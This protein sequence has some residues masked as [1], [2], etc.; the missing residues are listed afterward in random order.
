MALPAALAIG[1]GASL[2]GSL[3]DN[4]QQPD[5]QT[6]S[7]L[8][9]EQQQLARELASII[10]GGLRRG[11][12]RYTGQLSAGVPSIMGRAQATVADLMGSTLV[13]T[14]AMPT[15]QLAP[16]ASQ[17]LQPALARMLSGQP[18]FQVDTQATQRAIEAAQAPVIRQFQE[19]ILP[20]VREQYVGG[21]TFWSRARQEAEARAAASLAESLA[22]QRAQGALADIEAQRQAALAG[23]QIA[24]QVAPTAMQYGLETS[25]QPFQ[26]ALAA[27]EQALREALGRAETQLQAA[28]LA[29]QLGGQQYQIEQSAL[30]R[31]YQEWLRTQPESSP[32]LQMAFQ[33][34][35]VPMLAA[36][37][38]PMQVSP[39]A[40][41]AGMFT[42]LLTGW[43]AG[44]A[45]SLSNLLAMG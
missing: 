1:L 22:A 24:A 18:V 28:Q 17:T 11:A 34:L 15:Y 44:G 26:A 37:Q 27:R 35:G 19:Q 29:G 33:F 9:P 13:P 12:Q 42:N 14:G 20:Q 38:P 5:I 6:I 45:P 4:R 43:L 41:A 16:F 7:T 21:G 23:A 2:L 31:A 3:L 10:S 8:T 32:W 39:W 30:D 25:M 36:Y 40:Q